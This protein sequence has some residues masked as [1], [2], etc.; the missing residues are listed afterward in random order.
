[1]EEE[2]ELLNKPETIDVVS[3]HMVLLWM[4]E[5]A[6]RDPAAFCRLVGDN[7]HRFKKIYGGGESIGDGEIVWAI[8]ELGI[9]MFIISSSQGTVYKIHFPGGERAY[10]ADRKTGSAISAFLERTLIDLS[11]FGAV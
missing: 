1:M 11:G 10:S 3:S 8:E 6:K 7:R 4:K 2:L 9:P 5:K